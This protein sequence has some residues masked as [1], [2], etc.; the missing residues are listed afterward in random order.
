AINPGDYPANA[1][2]DGEHDLNFKLV[3][4]DEA[5]NVQSSDFTVKVDTAPPAPATSIDYTSLTGDETATID[6]SNNINIHTN[7]N[8]TDLVVNTAE[9]TAIVQLWES[10]Q[11]SSGSATL[12]LTQL[13]N[14][15]LEEG[16][17]TYSIKFIDD[18]GN[19]AP[20]SDVTLTMEVD[21][22]PTAVDIAL[23]NGSDRGFD[24]TDTITSGETF[25]FNGHFSEDGVDDYSDIG[26]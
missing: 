10:A 6:A 25:Q 15:I 14:N 23:D 7:D 4:V 11:V 9:D 26:Y 19:H 22:N 13:N 20:A 5:G 1:L 16:T 17:K 8:R 24:A 2:D 3:T 18:V 21:T 12:D